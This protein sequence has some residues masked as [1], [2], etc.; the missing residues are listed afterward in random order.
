MTHADD[1]VPESPTSGDW[2][3]EI[4]AEHAGWYEIAELVRTLTPAEC[5]LPGY[6]TDP[7]WTVRDMVAHVG[8][9]LAQAEVHLEQIAAGTYEGHEIDIDAVNAEMLAAMHD[10]PWEVAWTMAN[11]ARTMMLQDWYALAVR[12]DE[13]AWWVD[14]SG[15]YH[16]GQHL[17][18][19]REWVAQLVAGR[20]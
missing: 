14:K 13:A 12:T 18:R 2:Q 8:S 5:L 7:D 16:Y 6:Y 1:H 15:G 3:A 20:R 11:A 19:L 17:P 4:D 9:W 10:Q